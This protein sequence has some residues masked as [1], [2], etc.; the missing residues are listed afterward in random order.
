MTNMEKSCVVLQV[1]RDVDKVFYP[2]NAP[3]FLPET[4]LLIM[5]TKHP[6]DSRS[7]REVYSDLLLL[8]KLGYPLWYPDL[9]E[10]LPQPY[11]KIGVSIGDVGYISKDGSFIFK[12]NA[13]NEAA[14]LINCRGVPENFQPWSITDDDKEIF[15]NMASP[16]TVFKEG[17]VI[18]SSIQAGATANPT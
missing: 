2:S 5:T 1:R 10:S 14:N 13:C 7:A 9:S 12:F 18:G 16:D 8:R 3:C 17:V 6:K 11:R 4:F 15:S